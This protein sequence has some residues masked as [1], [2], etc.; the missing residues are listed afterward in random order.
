MEDVVKEEL[1]FDS[2]EEIVNIENGLLNIHTG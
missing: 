1:Q 2:D